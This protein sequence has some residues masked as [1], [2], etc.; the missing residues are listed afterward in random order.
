MP[1]PGAAVSFVMISTAAVQNIPHSKGRKMPVPLR[2]SCTTEL[3][4]PSLLLNVVP[5]VHCQ[6]LNTSLAFPELPSHH[7]KLAEAWG[8]KTRASVPL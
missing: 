8:D 3:R 4:L 6:E 7:G 2:R 5:T 1:G